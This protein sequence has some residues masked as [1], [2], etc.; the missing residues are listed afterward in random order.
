MKE[1]VEKIKSFTD[2][3]VWQEGHKLVIFVYKTTDSFPQKEIYGLVSQ[4]RR[5][6]VSITSNI[7]EGFS[8]NS[9]KEKVQFYYTAK[10][11]LSE[12]QNQFIIAKD[13]GYSDNAK[14]EE[15]LRRIEK[16]SRLIYGLIRSIKNS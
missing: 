1:L 4:M 11:S 6:A 13:L 5:A 14:Y 12:I 2:L 9:S 8:R 3:I 16:V 10:G 15:G 7:A